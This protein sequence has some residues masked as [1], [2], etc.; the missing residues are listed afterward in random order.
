MFANGTA[1]VVGYATWRS[2]RPVSCP[3]R[4]GNC[5]GARQV[6]RNICKVGCGWLRYRVTMTKGIGWLKC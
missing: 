1:V 6:W 4:P 5:P 3:V 2:N